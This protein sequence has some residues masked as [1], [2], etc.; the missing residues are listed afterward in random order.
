M[1]VVYPYLGYCSALYKEL[2][3]LVLLYGVLEVSVTE[4]TGIVS[5]VQ[6]VLKIIRLENSK[7]GSTLE[8][9]L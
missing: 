7:A 3:E 9:I 4:L 1:N 6:R 2:T 8:L 5:R